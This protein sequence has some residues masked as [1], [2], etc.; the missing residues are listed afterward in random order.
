MI[1]NDLQSFD[2]DSA[3][4]KVIEDRNVTVAEYF[5]ERQGKRLEHANAHL[6]YNRQG[7]RLDYFPAEL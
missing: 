3:N 1:K 2:S 6:I 7:W 4:T 5:H